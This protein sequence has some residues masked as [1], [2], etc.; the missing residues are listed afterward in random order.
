VGVMLVG[1]S[2][3]GKT[4]C[5]RVLSEAI[6]TLRTLKDNYLDTSVDSFIMNPKAVSHLYLCF[7]LILT[8]KG[9]N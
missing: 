7:T 2:M 4:T 9:Y 8:S 5:Y 6:N 3:S 1:D